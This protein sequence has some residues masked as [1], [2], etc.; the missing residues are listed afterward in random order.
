MVVRVGLGRDIHALV[1]GR[2]L[3]LG[4]QCVAESVGCL[5]HSDGDCLIHAL[6]DSLLGAAALPNIGVLFPD[7]DE[8][9]RGRSSREM[10][11]EVVQLVAIHGFHPVN[12]D[13]VIQLEFFAL[14]PFLV[15]M[16]GVLAEVLR[17]GVE[18]VGIKATSAEGLG[19][20]GEGKAVEVL[21]VCLLESVAG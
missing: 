18:N 12:V 14:N 8:K 1:S 4:G 13:A 16:R 3:I 7:W 9:N 17:I 5:A 2:R 6:M 19:P 11:S 21:C 20:V 10:L 15:K